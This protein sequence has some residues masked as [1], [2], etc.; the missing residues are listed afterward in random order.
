MKRPIVAIVVGAIL[1]ATLMYACARVVENYRG[2]RGLAVTP[3]A[4]VP[5]YSATCAVLRYEE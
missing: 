4:Y 2:P 5:P 1:A 3:V